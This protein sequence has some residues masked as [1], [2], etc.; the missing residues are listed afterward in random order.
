MSN[1]YF[2]NEVINGLDEKLTDSVANEL[3]S[4]QKR[5]DV[6]ISDYIVE[7]DETAKKGR[8]G[9]GIIALVACI[10]VMVCLAVLTVVIVKNNIAVQPLDSN[11]EYSH[12][13][14]EV[15]YTHSVKVYFL[16]KEL[17]KEF[18]RDPDIIKNKTI[19]NSIKTYLFAGNFDEE[20]YVF[21]DIN[22]ADQLTKIRFD[23]PIGGKTGMFREG[24]DIFFNR[25]L[26][27]FVCDGKQLRNLADNEYKNGY[28]KKVEEIT[29]VFIV[30]VPD[31]P[32]FVHFRDGERVYYV[33]LDPSIYN[34]NGNYPIY[35]KS[36]FI[37]YY[38]MKEPL[39]FI[40]GKEQKFV[41]DLA[42]CAASGKSEIDIVRLLDMIFDDEFIVTQDKVTYI[43]KRNMSTGKINPFAIVDAKNEQIKIKDEYVTDGELIEIW[44]YYGRYENLRFKDDKLIVD[45]ARAR[46]LMAYFAIDIHEYDAVNNR[47]DISYDE[48]SNC[49]SSDVKFINNDNIG[50]YFD[51]HN[52]ISTYNG[53]ADISLVISD[54]IKDI[55]KGL[56]IS[57]ELYV[58]DNG[59]PIPVNGKECYQFS[60]V[61]L[62]ESEATDDRS[63]HNV[64]ISIN[65]KNISFNKYGYS[66]NLKFILKYKVEGAESVT[67]ITESGSKEVDDF[68]IRNNPNNLSE[69]HLLATDPL[70]QKCEKQKNGVWNMTVDLSPLVT[71]NKNFNGLIQFIC[72]EENYPVK[73]TN[74][75]DEETIS[76][77]FEFTQNDKLV[78]DFTLLNENEEP[79]LTMFLLI[80]D[81]ENMATYRQK[82]ILP[83]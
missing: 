35:T 36:K 42:Y 71:E 33:N 25:E 28:I 21:G 15:Q 70:F 5:N 64:N 74:G 68:S 55:Y 52:I 11:S 47:I 30:C 37:N 31:Y 49:F 16:E 3:F 54:P 48:S 50:V 79:T 65:E 6:E 2:W 72:E 41:Q 17:G 56:K 14:E 20:Y 66:N 83:K 76:I 82:F 67:G 80:Q 34:G 46:E 43:Y 57:Y 60:G 75:N 19:A 12:L 8:K 18:I 69:E 7:G 59:V 62:A 39:L 78:I 32:A 63:V 22:K 51:E 23:D 40:N 4:Y 81:E 10:A 61:L 26:L 27:E 38:E 53:N 24:W 73:L 77:S 45:I 58:E 9:N 1:K 29:D 13:T 44:N